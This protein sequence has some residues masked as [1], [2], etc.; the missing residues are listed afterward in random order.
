[1]D[2][3]FLI[4]LSFSLNIIL[5]YFGKKINLVDV[6]TQRKIHDFNTPLIGGISIYC[7]LF[8]IYSLFSNFNDDFIK[9]LLLNS[10]LIVLLGII[11]DY[12]NINYKLRV[13]FIIFITCLIIYLT[14]IFIS[15]LGIFFN[16]KFINL[17]IIGLLFTI[18][19]VFA[20][21]NAFNFMDGIDGL[22]AIQSITILS[23]LSFYNIYFRLDNQ[24]TFNL[25]L[26]VI[27][28][29]FIIFN[30]FSKKKFKIFLGDAGSML[31]GFIISWIVIYMSQNFKPLPVILIPWILSYP[32][33]DL[34]STVIIRILKNKSPFKPDHNHFHYLLLKNKNFSVYKINAIIFL[35]SITMNVIGLI[36]YIFLL[37]ELSF[38][39]FIILF[40]FF[41]YYKWNQVK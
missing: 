13:F 15:N 33:F 32:I 6:P 9:I 28:F 8:I 14:E 2:Y 41:H 25:Y 40:L 5:Y 39:I 10:S 35:I 4:I 31:L 27:L 21:V 20:L 3:F 37:E 30:L 26:I 7:S 19:S 1:M 38:I 23:I 36:T 24:I 18:F 34:V 12:K 11:D 16:I 29:I 22:V 17:G